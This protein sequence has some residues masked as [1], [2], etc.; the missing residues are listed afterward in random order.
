MDWRAGAGEREGAEGQK[1]AGRA[2]DRRRA[3][4]GAA[5]VHGGEVNAART[6]CLCSKI[7]IYEKEE[8]R[9]RKQGL[10]RVGVPPQGRQ[11]PQTVCSS[12]VRRS[13]ARF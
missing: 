7:Y 10:A 6:T 9:R 4:Q 12:A 1:G 8:R 5:V 11:E 3:G 2:R 13:V